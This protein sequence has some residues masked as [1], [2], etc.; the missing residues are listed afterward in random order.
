MNTKQQLF[1]K[2]NELS[3]LFITGGY[4]E[5]GYCSTP[6]CTVHALQLLAVHISCLH[7]SFSQHIYLEQN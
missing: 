6:D 4:E 3:P 7:F 1:L 5:V 2:S